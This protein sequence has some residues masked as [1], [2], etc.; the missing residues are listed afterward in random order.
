MHCCVLLPLLTLWPPLYT[1][2]LT[3]FMPCRCALS[4]AEYYGAHHPQLISQLPEHV[5]LLLGVVH[6]GGTVGYVTR[7]A[8]HLIDI[9]VDQ[10]GSPA[11]AR[12][13]FE[14]WWAKSNLEQELAYLLANKHSRSFDTTT[15]RDIRRCAH[16]CHARFLHCHA[17]ACM[18]PACG[19]RH[20]PL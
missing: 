13:A 11:K 1:H 17:D 14:K 4:A 5:Q 15:G 8:Y 19:S 9:L 3:P 10:L 20:A 6:V 18:L 2:F 7:E 12:D 16:D